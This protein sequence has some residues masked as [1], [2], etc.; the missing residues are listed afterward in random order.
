[1]PSPD[2]LTEIDLKLLLIDLN[3]ADPRRRSEAAGKLANSQP[4][5]PRDAVVAALTARLKETD[6]SLRRNAAQAL[7]V[8]GNSN[9]VPD[10]VAALQGFGVFAQREIVGALARLKSPAAAEALADLLPRNSVVDSSGVA[11]ALVAIGPAAEPAVSRV[12]LQRGEFMTR[13]RACEILRQIGTTNSIPALTTVAGDLDP[14]TAR[15]AMDAL[16]AIYERQPPST[17]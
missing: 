15:A 14:S 12:L 1:M 9:A 5:E 16:R 3:S 11:A 7:G 17:Q 2:K 13:R 10:L 6:P 4:T 8:W